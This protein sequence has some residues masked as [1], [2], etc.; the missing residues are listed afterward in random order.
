MKQIQQGDVC[1]ER[2]KSIPA[3]ATRVIREPR[4]Y[5]L[6]RGEATG[7][8][9][10]IAEEVELYELDGVLYLKNSSPVEVTHEEHKTKVVPAGIW[11]VQRV[12][13]HDHISDM[14]RR[15]QD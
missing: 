11:E 10:V 15:V 4:G 6:A 12:R 5:I 7:H 3:K 1:M 14:T 2:V 8:A 9:H 13:E